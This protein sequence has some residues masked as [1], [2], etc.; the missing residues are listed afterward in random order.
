MPKQIDWEQVQKARANL[1]T[2]KSQYTDTRP[3]NEADLHTALDD[4]GA[5]TSNA[6]HKATYSPAEV[7]TMLGVH[8]ETVLRA[9][10]SGELQ[11]ALLGKMY[12][13]TPAE[14]NRWFVS[15]GGTPLLGTGGDEV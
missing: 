11:A 8:K 15:K 5:G 9:I 14:L 13:I 1:D 4:T 7:A 12:R 2:I 10:R 3:M 6:Q